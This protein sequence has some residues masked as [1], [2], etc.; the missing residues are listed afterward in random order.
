MHKEKYLFEPC[1]HSLL[2]LIINIVLADHMNSKIYRVHLLHSLF[3]ICLRN[4][5]KTMETVRYF[6]KKNFY[7][8]MALRLCRVTCIHIQ[9]FKRKG[10]WPY[11]LDPVLHNSLVDQLPSHFVRKE[12]VFCID[13]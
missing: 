2:E 6:V 7:I 11:T 12:I 9:S 3:C 10:I 1:F 13:M 4:R 8:N 5:Q